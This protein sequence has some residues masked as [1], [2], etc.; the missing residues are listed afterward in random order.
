[1]R[2]ETSAI[3]TEMDAN[4]CGPVSPERQAVV[5]QRHPRARGRPPAVVAGDVRLVD[6]AE[7][8]LKLEEPEGGQEGRLV[9]DGDAVPA[10]PQA[11]REPERRE[12]AVDREGEE[13]SHAYDLTG[14]PGRR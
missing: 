11:E 7:R 13:V 3:R 10:R 14:R 6:V 1:M 8:G 12:P 5:S 2:A 9:G 4:P